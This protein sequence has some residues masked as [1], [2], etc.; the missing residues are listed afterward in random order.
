MFSPVPNVVYL[1][2]ANRSGDDALARLKRNDLDHRLMFSELG[3]GAGTKRIA[4]N[5]EH[6]P[7]RLTKRRA[8]LLKRP[9]VAAGWTRQTVSNAICALSANVVSV[10]PWSF[11]AAD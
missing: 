8:Q 3:A 5:S 10:W 6:E 4:E 7:K 2:L 11:A 1:D 9:H